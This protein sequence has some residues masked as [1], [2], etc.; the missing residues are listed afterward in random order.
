MLKD[1]KNVKTVSYIVHD[2]KTN[3][4]HTYTGCIV[5]VDQEGH[6][7]FSHLADAF[8]QSDLHMR[9]LQC[10]HILHLH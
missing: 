6:F 8:I 9:D 5:L 10:I 3:V 2:I 1:N 7:T 4:G